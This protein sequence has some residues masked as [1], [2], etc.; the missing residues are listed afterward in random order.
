MSRTES[1]SS[2]EVMSTSTRLRP[3][4]LLLAATLAG[5]CAQPLE[6]EAFPYL[7]PSP[8]DLVV[9]I[10]D[11]ESQCLS[12]AAQFA[13]LFDDTLADSCAEMAEQMIQDDVE[14]LDAQGLLENLESIRHYTRDTTAERIST[15][16][17]QRR[18]HE[19]SAEQWLQMSW[20]FWDDIM[21]CDEYVYKRFFDVSEFMRI[22]DEY[23]GDP[24]AYM[25]I[26]FDGG[27][28]SSLATAEGFLDN[29]GL[30]WPEDQP[31]FV[32]GLE[33]SY[34]TLH[35]NGLPQWTFAPKNDFFDLS[36]EERSAVAAH[37]DLT[38]GLLYS[39]YYGD[40][41]Q[42]FG[43]GWTLHQERYEALQAEPVATLSYFHDVRDEFVAFRDRRRRMVDEFSFYFPG[44]ATHLVDMDPE[45]DDDEIIA[46][47]YEPIEFLPV[48]YSEAQD[49][50]YTCLMANDRS[51]RD[52]ED[53]NSPVCSLQRAAYKQMVRHE[54]NRMNIE[55]GLWL[56]RAES[57]GCLEGAVVYDSPV[58]VCDW[59]PAD[60]LEDVAVTLQTC[61]GGACVPVADRMEQER[62]TCVGA[63]P[64]W[65]TL[66]YGDEDGVAYRYYASS[67][68]YVA[69]PQPIR[70]AADADFF[71]S[72]ADVDLY[73]ERL[74]DEVN[75]K[76]EALD[77]TVATLERGN[78]PKLQYTASKQW[79]ERS[80]LGI[81]GVDWDQIAAGYSYAYD[82]GLIDRRLVEGLEHDREDD[83]DSDRPL[84]NP[85]PHVAAHFD[86]W[87]EAFGAS[88]DAAEFNLDA[89]VFEEEDAYFWSTR[90]DFS[91]IG[92]DLFTPICEGA[93]QEGEGELQINQ[94]Y[95]ISSTPERL[96]RPLVPDVRVP[97]VLAGIPMS[98]RTEV[99]GVVGLDWDI[100]V[101]AGGR[102]DEDENDCFE[103]VA[104][105][106]LTLTPWVSLSA[107]GKAGPDLYL[108]SAGAYVNVE[109]LGVRLPMKGGIELSTVDFSSV[110]ADVGVD[111][112][113][114]F[115]TLE[116]SV[117][118]YVEALS[119]EE[120]WGFDWDGLTTTVNVYN[121]DYRW[122]S[123]IWDGVCSVMSC[124]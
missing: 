66:I 101:I 20:D 80:D 51:F 73:M 2:L 88:V 46:P 54:L 69:Q 119:W 78:W 87:G 41:T 74:T 9:P 90:L 112:D 64:D 107:T 37:S 93:C 83:F 16:G 45:G 65:L 56:T 104:G 26:A 29:E 12:P 91:L 55:F 21:S 70:T 120:R 67:A 89:R 124:I 95:N 22:A 71:L 96:E 18:V 108:V 103:F 76:I 79:S 50:F 5:L 15:P 34:Q 59:S 121:Q 98:T 60:F 85:H 123:E 14:A 106:D 72:V 52:L 47:A 13:A 61:E 97:F 53:L 86:A 92:V 122:R 30:W 113:V 31:R 17:V 35:P 28:G 10:N 117:G 40:Y 38:T 81:P 4:P 32:G 3:V 105:A 57:M 27:L 68:D 8:G 118:L 102:D 100:D 115:T 111:I 62:A 94:P 75:Y 44:E 116:G 49:D 11:F 19:R 43:G 23:A 1:W 84:C 39:G 77:D 25:D 99:T 114:I 63:A 24:M 6:A 36:F 48:S 82:V 109:L 58:G 42:S 110:T 33:A 7:P